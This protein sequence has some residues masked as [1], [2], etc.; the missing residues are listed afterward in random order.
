MVE[1]KRRKN[2]LKK[3]L[4]KPFLSVKISTEAQKIQRIP[5]PLN[6]QG[7]LGMIE[8]NRIFNNSFLTELSRQK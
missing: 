2:K 7:A 1:I 6:I 4:Q 3:E 8:G 5:V